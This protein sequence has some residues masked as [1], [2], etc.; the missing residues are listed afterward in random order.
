MSKIA[1]VVKK[2]QEEKQ[3]YKLAK[4]DQIVT[5]FMNGESYVINPLDT[6]KMVTASSIFGEPSYYRGS[7]CISN[8]PHKLVSNC[9][10]TI[11]YGLTTDKL[12]EQVIDKAL[13]YDYSSVLIWAIDLRKTF[14]MR[15]NPQ[16]IMVRAALHPNRKTYTTMCPGSF[17]KINCSVMSR[18]DDVMVQMAYYMYLMKDKNNIPSI[19]K[20]SW[21]KKISNLDRYEV[22]KYKNHEI[23]LINAV[24]IC[25]ANSPVIDELMTTGAV[26]VSQEEKTWENLRSQGMS[27]KDVVNTTHMGHMALLRNIRNVF[28]EVN[29]IEFC[30]KYIECLKRGVESGKQFP[31][32][33][34]T[35]LKVLKQSSCNHKQMLEDGLTECMEIA[36]KNLPK[37]KGRTMCLSDNS[38]SAWEVFNSEYGSVT[39]AEID[40]LSSVISAFN[41]DEGF[42]GTF[43]DNLKIQSVSK[44][45]SV[46]EQTKE[47]DTGVGQATEAGVWKFFQKAIDNKEHW[48]NIFIYSDM[49]AGHGELYGHNSEMNEYHMRYGKA[50]GFNTYIN[51][52]ELILEYRRKVNPKVNV[53]SVQTAGYDDV[54]VPEMAYRTAILYGWTGKELTFANEYISLWNE[55]EEKEIKN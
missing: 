52:Y 37:L 2:E 25:H 33:Y 22:A 23:G 44:K 29:D 36:M 24:R 7:N 27:W 51:V 20:R 15:L 35:A 13:E 11:P 43:G 39:V 48:D 45:K 26:K 40:N 3:Q 6:L 8:K 14:N 42:V 10:S 5:N 54:V 50:R 41:S 32:R 53:F 31:F 17:G 55:I 19:L 28:S 21:A 18:A 1:K 49:Q 4:K 47:L 16:I 34:Y 9:I 12:M 30:K 46:L 38:G